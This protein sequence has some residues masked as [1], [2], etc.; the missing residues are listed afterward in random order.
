M[1]F[2]F[3]LRAKEMSSLSIAD[4]RRPDGFIHDTINLTINKTKGDKNRHVFL[5]NS[6]VFAS[7]KAYSHL[8]RKHTLTEPLFLSQKGGRFTPNTL[9]M[10][11]ASIYRDAGIDGAS[12]HSGRRTFATRLGVDIKAVGRLM[13]H[14]SISMTAEYIEDN[15]E[16]LKKITKM[17]L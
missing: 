14:S 9:Q 12:S 17:V 15:P 11:F 5:T 1:S 7:L 6:A 2:G 4:V 10:L 16:R 13:G 3:G 8:R